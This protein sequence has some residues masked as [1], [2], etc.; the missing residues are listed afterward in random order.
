[1]PTGTIADALQVAHK[2]RGLTEVPPNSNICTITQRL[3]DLYGPVPLY[4]GG[5]SYRSRQSW[6]AGHVVNLLDEAGVPCV[7]RENGG[8]LMINGV[9]INMFYTPSDV[10]AFQRAG[11]WLGPKEPA[12]VGAAV[13]Y[14]WPGSKFISDHVGWVYATAPDGRPVTSEGNTSPAGLVANG[15]GVYE[16]GPGLDGPLRPASTIVG[17]GII[18]YNNVA[19]PVPPAPGRK[20][21]MQELIQLRNHPEIYL[22]D[23]INFTYR[24]IQNEQAL[25]DL[26]WNRAQ[27]GNPIELSGAAQTAPDSTLVWDMGGGI[28]ANV[29]VVDSLDLFG[30]PI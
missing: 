28:V 7:V 13:F 17:Y 4:G 6:C 23:G 1:M 11:A 24:H 16:F 29:R 26:V 5:R 3:D 10:Q 19:T 18:P 21:R 20:T 30:T 9:F 15:G 8:G 14:R 27:N 25:K 2:Y 12:P 22:T